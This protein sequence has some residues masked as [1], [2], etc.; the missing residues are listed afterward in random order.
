M[1]P[2]ERYEELC[3]MISY[4]M[5]RYYNQDDPEITDREYDELMMELRALEKENPGLV[6]P[7]SPTQH[8][9]G[10][11]KREAGVLVRHN[12]PMLSLQDVFSKEEVFEFV[13]D[14]QKQL[15]DPEFVVEYKIDGLSLVLRYEDGVLKLAETRGDGVNFGEDVTANAKVIN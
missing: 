7:D 4:H 1:N 14:M 5:D 2:S 12:V 15:A 11:A 10:S 3:R 13:E 9:G 6:T 8:V